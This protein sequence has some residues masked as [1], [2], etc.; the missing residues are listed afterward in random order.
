MGTLAS[1]TAGNLSISEDSWHYRVYDYWKSRSHRN[2]SRRLDLCHYFWSVVLWA[3]LAYLRT[4]RVFRGVYLWMVPM[5]GL[6]AGLITL[7]AM[8][9]P[10]E[11]LSFFLGAVVF[12][13]ICAVGVAFAMFCERYHWFRRMVDAL[14]GPVMHVLVPIW[15][16]LVGIKDLFVHGVRAFMR[17]R[18]LRVIIP[19]TLAV[20]L[21]VWGLLTAPNATG[22]T[23]LIIGLM[24]VV[25]VLLAG[26]V[27]ML[28]FL[29]EALVSSRRSRS[30]HS[31]RSD[32][33]SA[34]R[35][36]LHFVS[37]KK[38]RICPFINVTKQEKIT[39]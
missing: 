23:L 9:A 29:L 1:L 34:A 6:L 21:I 11:T 4:T 31:G 37:S 8:V 35:V 14:E 2:S 3:P 33:D 17:H 7:C 39:A 15:D 28:V 19:A 24:I 27:W 18:R 25:V 20:L 12:V 22:Q 10:R 32:G 26:L 36:V 13:L 30:R 16:A 38:R 5:A